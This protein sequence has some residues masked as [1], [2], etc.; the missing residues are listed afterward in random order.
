MPLAGLDGRIKP[1]GRS[2]PGPAPAVP[3]GTDA[4]AIVAAA[5]TP[6]GAVLANMMAR[7]PRRRRRSASPTSPLVDRAQRRRLVSPAPAPGD[8]LATFLRDLAA[9][10]GVVTDGM[11]ELLELNDWSP[12]VLADAEVTRHDIQEH[13]KVPSGTAIKIKRFATEWT[14]RLRL[15]LDV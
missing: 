7:S 14:A 1:R 15:K 6:F 8:E 4:A 11:A 10:R 3:S 13:L 12:D 5:M 9:Q 2:G